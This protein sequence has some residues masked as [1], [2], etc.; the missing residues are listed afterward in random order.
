M[1]HLF[2]IAGLMLLNTVAP[3]QWH[4]AGDRIKTVWGENISPD[5][6]L[7]EYPRPILARTEWQNL[8]GLWDFTTAAAAADVPADYPEK[9]LVPFP[10]ESSLSG[11]ARQ[12]DEKHVMWY[13]R[14][15]TIP[16][17][18]NKRRIIL[19]F[20]AVDWKTDVFVNGIKVGSHTGGYAPFSFDITPF[21]HT[22]RQTLL[23]RV[24]D[25]TDKYFQPRGKQVSQPDGIVYTPS[26]GIWQTVW[27]EPVAEKHIVALKTLPDV[28]RSVFTL[29]I[30]TQN[31]DPQD[32]VEVLLFDGDKTVASVKSVVSEAV[33]LRVPEAKLWSPDSP[34]L[35]GLKI[36]L[37]SGG[38]PV[39]RITSYCALRK[40]SVKRDASGIMRMQLNNK[41]LIH[42]GLLDQGFWPD[43]LHTAPSDEAL[44]YDIVTA[45]ELGYNM[46][47][48]HIKVE[49]A[50]WYTWCD[51]LGILV[52][53]D[54]PSGDNH[55]NPTER[56]LN[57]DCSLPASPNPAHENFLK[58]WKEIIDALY[59]YPSIVMW[60]P[61]N[62]GWGRFNTAEV[63]ACTKA[64]D[65]SRLLNTDT[66]GN[67]LL[68]GDLL[69][70]HTYPEP[71]L[72]LYDAK[73][74]VLLGEYGG[75]ALVATDHLWQPDKNF[76]YVQF[77]SQKEATDKYEEYAKMLYELIFKGFSGAVYTQLSD[78]EGEANGLL[79]Y[80]RKVLKLD[81]DRLRTL[82]R[83]I[84][85]ALER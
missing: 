22:G 32:Y 85:E 56:N 79:S 65:P 36:S 29:N 63:S 7:P 25:P 83:K 70:V 82:N 66:G 12:I 42:L 26:S 59:S 14:T 43:G 27:M 47:R 75:I 16:R 41:D 68:D 81:A 73:R 10:L 51:R 80:D 71:R 74:P 39:D 67:N 50:R 40:I 18:W 2:F 24:W 54:M 61:F 52:W 60:V 21:L 53:Q 6:V 48:K 46:L 76:G 15:F 19:H 9:I 49:P 31:H 55:W 33:T 44:K 84:V 13:R 38:K 69:D 77:A 11:L 58:E 45:K 72:T 35:Y 30:T 5:N 3:A 34:F 64:W 8:N 20:G 57:L 17:T 37:F 4:P 23:V 28:D 1:K 62:E 78:V